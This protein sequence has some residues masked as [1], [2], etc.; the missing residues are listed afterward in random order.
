MTK[1]L[2]SEFEVISANAALREACITIF[3]AATAAGVT[4][5]APPTGKGKPSESDIISEGEALKQYHTD[6]SALLAKRPAATAAT[7]TTAASAPATANAD[8][9]TMYARLR[10]TCA[11]LS[12][13]VRARGQSVPPPPIETGSLLH[14]F[15]SL[16]NYHE[17][18]L[19]DRKA[20]G[21]GKSKHSTVSAASGSARLTADEI[22]MLTWTERAQVAGGHM[23]VDQARA[24]IANRDG[25]KEAKRPNLTQRALEARG[26]TTLHQASNLRQHQGADPLD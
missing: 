25:S 12:E 16:A 4:V 24:A 21:T 23:S 9:G 20:G 19:L 17:Q 22:R 15:V 13:S 8:L 5:Q 18:L 14:D 1:I 6:I 26:C 11:A 2:P 7:A 10:Q 3:N